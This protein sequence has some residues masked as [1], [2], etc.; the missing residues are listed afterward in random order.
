MH[1]ATPDSRRLDNFMLGSTLNRRK[2]TSKLTTQRSPATL[3]GGTV[4]VPRW[5]GTTGE[6]VTACAH[7]TSVAT[8]NATTVTAA[9]DAN[10]TTTPPNEPHADA[11]SALPPATVS[12]WDEWENVH[13]VLATVVGDDSTDVPGRRHRHYL[14]RSRVLAANR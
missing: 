13:T 12:Q 14:A 5:H 7:T 8:A 9:A 1:V 11:D 3:N 10:A 2:S 6:D 4:V